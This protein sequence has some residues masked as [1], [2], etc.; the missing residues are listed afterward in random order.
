MLSN[1]RPL[2]RIVYTMLMP[3][4]TFGLVNCEA[5]NWTLNTSWEATVQWR[6]CVRL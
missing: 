1:S 2:A 5:S 3:A 4:S 6:S